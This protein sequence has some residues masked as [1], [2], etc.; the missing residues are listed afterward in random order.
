MELDITEDIVVVAGGARGIGLEIA[1]GFA[2]EG[3][4][5]A[6]VDI[7]EDVES[8]AR[9]LGELSGTRTVGVRCDITR[10]DSNEAAR[11]RVETEL[12]KHR[13]LVAAAAIGSGKFGYPFLELSPDDWRRV[14]EVNV[15][16]IV[17]FVHTFSPALIEQRSGTITF[18]N[19]VAAHFGSQTDPPYSASKAALLNFAQC[20]ARD[21]APHGVRVNSICPGMVKTALNRNV[22]EA[23]NRRQKP[24]HR[25]SYEDWADE[26]VTKVVPLGRWQEAEDIAD[27]A[28]FLASRRAKN[29]T[30][31]T[32]NVDGGYVMR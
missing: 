23:W 8:V 28:V 25:R 12:G 2:A 7:A 26:K 22:W 19:S 15:E 17:R 24:E 18:I 29:I 14:L 5:V 16:G 20:V 11:I 4:S 1:K 27:L 31:Q 10:S 13:H 30:G 3:A 9:S 32:I 6:I 21:L